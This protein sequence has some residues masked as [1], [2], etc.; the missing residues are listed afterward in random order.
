VKRQAQ[1]G[2]L[3]VRF[4]IKLPAKESTAIEKAVEALDAAME[5]DL[6]EDI[7]F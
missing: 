3:Y 4:A 6:R 7:T 5:G 2:D 1:Q